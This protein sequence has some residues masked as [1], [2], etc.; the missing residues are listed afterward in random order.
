M[1]NL[2]QASGVG[3]LDRTMTV[4]S[5]VE[6][7]PRTFTEIADAT[8]WSRTT[9]HRLVKAMLGHGLLEVDGAREYRLGPRLLS[10]ASAALRDR[11]LGELA[12]PTLERLSATTGESAQLYVRDGDRRVCVDAVESRSELRTIVAVGASL[13]LLRGSAGKVFLA[14]SN[15]EDLERVLGTLGHAEA[16]RLRREVTTVGRRGWASS[17]GEREPG[18]ASVTAPILDPEGTCVAAIS[19]SGPAVRVGGA[20]GRRHVP[21]VLAAAREIGRSLGSPSR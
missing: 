11:S 17:A 10:L 15:D 21:A 18:V 9:T 1:K 5:L 7:E 19:V 16:A 6:A 2:P 13:G 20:A 8:G 14:W 3:V 12:H 4:L